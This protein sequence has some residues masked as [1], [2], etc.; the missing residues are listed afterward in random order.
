MTEVFALGRNIEAVFVEYVPG[1]HAVPG[2][3]EG[4]TDKLPGERRFVFRFLVSFD[5]EHAADPF[6][7]GVVAERAP[8]NKH[9]QTVTAVS[10]RINSAV[11]GQRVNRRYARPVRYS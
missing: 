6:R 10:G 11:S 8:R 7:L 5:R 2:N 4:L 9:L 1:A 3:P